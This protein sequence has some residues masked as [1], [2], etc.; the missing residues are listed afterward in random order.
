MAE[1]AIGGALAITGVFVGAGVTFAGQ[2]WLA[3]REISRHRVGV[4]RALISELMQNG[5]CVA[6][7]LY[8]GVNVLK[9]SSET[10]RSTRY[11]LG[12]FLPWKLYDEIDFLYQMLHSTEDMCSGPVSGTS[13]PLLER[14]FAHLK[15]AIE[16][17]RSLPEAR[18]FRESFKVDEAIERAEQ[19][20]NEMTQP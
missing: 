6:G 5:A 20:M 16:D 8:Q 18:S 12:Q 3:D 11:E 2:K 9:F 1:L 14:W 19:Q 7:V 15:T 4:V 10:W 13:L 17:L